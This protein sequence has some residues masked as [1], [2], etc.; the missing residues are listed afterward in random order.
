MP[1]QDVPLEFPVKGLSVTREFSQQPEGTTADCDN[2][3]SKD[4][5]AGRNRGGSRAGFSKY[6]D[7]QSNNGS[8]QFQ[9]MK[10]IVDPTS[11]ALTQ[12]FLTPGS[13]WIPHPRLPGIL[14]PPGGAPWQPNP[15]EQ[16]NTGITRIQSKRTKYDAAAGEQTF[17]F[18]SSIVNQNTGIVAV[19]THVSG[20]SG[21]GVTVTNGSGTAYTQVGSYVEILDPRTADGYVRLSLWKKTLNSGS[22]D[23]TVKVTPGASTV[24]LVVV[25]IEYHGMPTSG[26]TDSTNTNSDTSLTPAAPAT[27]GNVNVLGDGELILGCF[28][29]ILDASGFTPSAGYSLVPNEDDGSDFDLRLNVSEKIGLDNPADDPTAVTGTT[30]GGEDPYVAIGATFKK[31]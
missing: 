2:V 26:Q 28:S 24:T 27:T 23:D 17:T 31:A 7:G 3:A 12:N 6:V 30:T 13:D 20:T 25:G 5:I 8:V 21:V 1:N 11:E 19:V 9:G 29:T 22:P 14:I 16:N 4:S 18:T 10:M 15:N